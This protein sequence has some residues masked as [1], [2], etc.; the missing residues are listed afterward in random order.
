MY[1]PDYWRLVRITMDNGEYVYKV[2]GTWVGGYTKGDEWRLNSG[3]DRVESWS[4]ENISGFDVFGASGS[5]YRIP[6]IEGVYRTSGYS[7][8]VLGQ[9]QDQ[10]GDRM[11][12]FDYKEA[13]ELLENFK[14]AS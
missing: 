1:N 4:N 13:V 6:K 5:C 2:F 8:G 9:Y 11:H 3:I 12:Q 7:G 10:L 14:N